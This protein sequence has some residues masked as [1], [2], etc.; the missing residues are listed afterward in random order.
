VD[1]QRHA[2]H[3]EGV[4][5]EAQALP[6]APA[7]RARSQGAQLAWRP[8][9]PPPMLHGPTVARRA[10]RP[11]RIRIISPGSILIRRSLPRPPW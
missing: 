4:A 2:L 7:S 6:R 8:A 9:A 5:S 3:A 10:Q 11:V 1:R